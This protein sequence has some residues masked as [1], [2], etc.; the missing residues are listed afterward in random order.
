[1]AEPRVV[2]EFDFGN[3]LTGRV[4]VDDDPGNPRIDWDNLGLMVFFH[5][6]YNLGDKDH[7]FNERDY[8]S[9]TGLERAILKKHGLGLVLP[10]YMYDHSGI[11]IST[12]PFSCPW[13][14]GQIGLIYG[15]FKKFKEAWGWK[16]MNTSRRAKVLEV[17][18]G[19]VE[20]YDQYLRGDVYGI[21]LYQQGD[22]EP[23][24][25]C[26]GFYGE[27][28]AEEEIKALAEHFRPKQ[29]SL[30]GVAA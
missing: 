26:Y 18:Q 27:E 2:K 4:V 5:K 10:V 30:P 23:I 28:S 17:L 14:S 11:T 9:W 6:R 7:G 15:S 24:D 21:E 19:E 13:D 8:H 3:R 29:L 12:K 16:A 25:S 22:D 1:M 20:T